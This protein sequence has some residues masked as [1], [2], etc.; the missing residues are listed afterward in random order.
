MPIFEDL[1]IFDFAFAADVAIA[2][3]ELSGA[4]IEELSVAYVALFE[5]GVAGAACP[6]YE[7]AY[8]SDPR[9]GQVAHL[10][11]DL[12]RSILR[13]GL[14][15]HDG[16]QDLVDHVATEMHVMAML[17]RREAEVHATDRPA[18][19]AASHQEEFLN[20]HLFLWVPAFARRVGQI[21]RHR[22]YTALAVATRAFLAHERQMLPLLAHGFPS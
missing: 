4:D 15:I 13:Y 22:A 10:Q 16:S 12:K 3:E 8:R 11:S 21:D 20:N 1:G 17:C 6:P 5:A 18:D 14:R 19:R 9:T 7:S 2:A